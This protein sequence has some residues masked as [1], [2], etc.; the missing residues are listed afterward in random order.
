MS[1]LNKIDFILYLYYFLNYNY[2]HIQKIYKKIF[3]NKT[4]KKFKLYLIFYHPILIYK[5]FQFFLYD[6]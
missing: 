2:F 1:H 6:H 5:N 4:N 3:K